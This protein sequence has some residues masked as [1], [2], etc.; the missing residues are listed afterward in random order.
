MSLSALFTSAVVASAVANVFPLTNKREY[1]YCDKQIR[2]L[3]SDGYFSTINL[4]P[5]YQRHIRWKPA[6]MN[7]FID[8]VMKKRYIMPVLMYRLS[9]SDLIGKYTPDTVFENEVMDGQHRLY[10]LNAFKSAKIQKLP[11]IS[12]EFIVHWVIEEKDENGKSLPKIHVFYEKTEDVENWCRENDILP[13]YLT[14][15]G[16]S[17]FNNTVIKLT[18]IVS[19]LTMNERRAEFL[20]LQN[21][22]P[23]RG[24]DLLKN[25]V[26]CKLMVEFNHHDY[27]DLMDNSFFKHCTKKAPQYKVNWA[28]R[29]YL[30]F[31]CH[32]DGGIHPSE[33]FLRGDKKI[34][35][36]IKTSHSSLSPSDDEFNEFHDKFLDFIEFLNS[37]PESTTFNPTQIFALFYHSCTPE[38][39]I[40]IL[41]SY[42]TYFSKEGHT[43]HLKNLWESST[44]EMEPR[45]EYFNACLGQLRS[46]KTIAN[47]YDEVPTK[48][49][50]P[51]VWAK[52][53]DNKCDI[54]D[55]EITVQN[56]H[57]GH[58][59]AR[60]RGGQT[61]VENLIP[62][63]ADC[64][65]SMGTRDAYEYKQDV[66]P[67]L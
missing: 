57:A 18:T 26:G 40:D 53:V 51:K 32:T 24:S 16:K 42:M 47:A 46:M 4:R 55:K 2:D 13:E 35:S 22:I 49:F 64:N 28:A 23:V 21:G 43:K 56:F 45:R 30:L 59:I 67:Y 41:R 27:E 17:Q 33:T 6:A 7:K 39:N 25:E 19:K 1:E 10:T 37:L 34:A 66:Y 29:C 11:Y 15:E 60:A 63:C 3:L 48:K 62:I 65:L 38:C 44:N 61:V 9:H 31:K 20:S 36:N 52:C 5:E 54:C 14:K 8:S 50:R 12:K 58:I